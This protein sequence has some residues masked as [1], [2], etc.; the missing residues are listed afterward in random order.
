MRW[1][2][3]ASL[4][5]LPAGAGAGPF[6]LE[7]LA[8]A[9][10][11]RGPL[12]L[13]PYATLAERYDS[14]VY[15]Q[16]DAAGSWIHSL[17]GGARASAE[18]SERQRVDLSYDAAFRTYS[19]DPSINNTLDQSASI[20]DQFR[21]ANGLSARAADAYVN[22]VD[23]ATSELTRRTRRWNNAATV[24]A[25]YAPEGGRL[26]AGVDAGETV[27]KYV[28][29]AEFAAALNRTTQLVGFKAGV[30]VQP[31]TRAYAA[32]HR[33]IIHY[34]DHPESPTKNSKAHLIDFGLEGELAPKLS[35][36]LQT[37]LQ[38]R[39]YDDEAVRGAGRE[40]R[41]WTVSGRLEY[42]PLE[43]TRVELLLGRSL[44]ESTFGANRY[45]LASSA[46]LNATHRFPWRAALG[47]SAG[48]E[49][50][51]YP[52]AEPAADG[53]ARG[54]RDDLVQAGAVLEYPFRDWLRAGLDYL[55]RARFSRG[56]SEFDYRDHVSGVWIAVG[57]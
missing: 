57:F 56:F 27:D 8:P 25:V 41:H 18:F 35:G 9:E 5:A 15:L 26:S 53:A 54:R 14:N 34:T 13:H 32:Y 30:L 33:R 50:D 37:G 43:R 3:A 44:Q 11:R 12:E 46:A 48:Y 40:S 45:Y 22:T 38:S 52:E 23:P 55:Y 19:R 49:R 17:A 28:S 20:A 39:R 47:L 51:Q 42:R 4:L 1:L 31:R 36:R 6:G 21:G 29:S 10:L 7:D 16:P 2:L 24:E